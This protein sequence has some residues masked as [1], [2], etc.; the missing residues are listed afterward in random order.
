[1][2]RLAFKDDIIKKIKMQLE[3][4]NLRI[5]HLEHVME[6]QRMELI[7]SDSQ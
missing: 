1:M 7:K 4:S 5:I 6:K 2:E 3:D